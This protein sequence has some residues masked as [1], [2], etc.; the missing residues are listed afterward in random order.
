MA[1]S[2][3]AT[4]PERQ[5]HRAENAIRQGMFTAPQTEIRNLMHG[6]TV[7]ASFVGAGENRSSSGTACAFIDGEDEWTAENSLETPQA[8]AYR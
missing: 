6:A 3:P 8:G 1:Q 5:S 7:A 2:S 4:V